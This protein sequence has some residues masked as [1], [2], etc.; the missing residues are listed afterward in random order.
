MQT[1]IPKAIGAV[2]T[3]MGHSGRLRSC[4]MTSNMAIDR[5][6]TVKLSSIPPISSIDSMSSLELRKNN[7]IYHT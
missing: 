5:G 7:G 2:N 3:Q 1:A 4:S 6:K